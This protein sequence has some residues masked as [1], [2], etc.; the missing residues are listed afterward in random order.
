MDTIVMIGFALFGYS[1]GRL[2]GRLIIY[3]MS[4]PD[5]SHIYHPQDL[6]IR[7]VGGY[8][9]IQ[10]EGEIALLDL[11]HFSELLLEKEKEKYILSFDDFYF[12]FETLSEAKEVYGMFVNELEKFPVVK[13]EKIS[14]KEEECSDN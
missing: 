7:K 9:E 4:Q 11:S 5:G 2:I 6:S 10:E 3:I 1:L 14:L 13:P 8:I 12:T